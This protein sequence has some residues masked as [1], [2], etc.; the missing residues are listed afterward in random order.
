[1]GYPGACISGGDGR[2]VETENLRSIGGNNWTIGGTQ[3]A[4]TCRSR[5]IVSPESP[6]PEGEET[7]RGKPELGTGNNAEFP[8][9][10]RSDRDSRDTI[11]FNSVLQHGDE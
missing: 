8:F 1:M 5:E 9:R 2:P 7:M 10:D 3:W 4:W 11:F 6:F